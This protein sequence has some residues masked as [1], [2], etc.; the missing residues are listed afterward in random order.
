MSLPDE[1]PYIDSISIDE[2]TTKELDETRLEAEYPGKQAWIEWKEH[3]ARDTHNPR[4]E[5]IIENRVKRL[6][7]QLQSENEPKY[8]RLLCV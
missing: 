1:A 8:F 6:A 4:Q 3:P 2:V 5:D 7:I